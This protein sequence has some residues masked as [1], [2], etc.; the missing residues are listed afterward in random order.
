MMSG[1]VTDE[2]GREVLPK[3]EPPAAATGEAI[4]TRRPRPASVSAKPTS[5]AH[6]DAA[7]HAITVTACCYGPQ[8]LHIIT[9]VCDT[10]VNQHNQR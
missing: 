9:V 4:Y 10:V 8:H 7:H 5:G 1:E 6:R 3:A 2:A